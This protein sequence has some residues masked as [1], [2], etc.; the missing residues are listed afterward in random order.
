MSAVH[1]LPDPVSA[2]SCTTC[3]S[4]ELKCCWARPTATPECPWRCL[5]L[6]PACQVLTIQNP[7]WGCCPGGRD[8]PFATCPPESQEMTSL[9]LKPLSFL[10]TP[11]LQKRPFHL[12]NHY[13]CFLILSCHVHCLS[14]C[15][16]QGLWVLQVVNTVGANPR[17]TPWAVGTTFAA[18]PCQLPSRNCLFPCRI[19]QLGPGRAEA[20]RSGLGQMILKMRGGKRGKKKSESPVSCNWQPLCS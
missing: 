7:F 3:V 19:P 4:A 15:S 6:P 1:L 8:R 12:F 14:V 2:G 18:T 9:R 13:S 20:S 5:L 10:V 17:R 16:A 11:P